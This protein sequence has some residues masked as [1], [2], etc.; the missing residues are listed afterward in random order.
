MIFDI[1]MQLQ[2][3]REKVT[4]Y[5]KLKKKGATNKITCLN[6][7]LQRALVNRYVNI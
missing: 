1:K 4:G 3:R 7:L 5:I 6:A 2:K